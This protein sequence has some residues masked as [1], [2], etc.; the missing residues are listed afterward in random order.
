MYFPYLRGKQFELEAL[1]EVNS[2]VF[3]N[4]LP[5]LE[6]ITISRRGLYARIAAN[7]IPLILVMNPYYP[8]NGRVS[9]AQIQNII[10]NE[11]LSHTSLVLGYLIDQR[12]DLNDFNLFLNTNT[13]RE[14]AII[15]RHNPFPNALISIQSAINTQGIGYVIFDERKA[16]PRTQAAFSTHPRR[17]LLTDGFQVQQRNADYPASSTFD[18]I[19]NSWRTDGWAGIGDYLTIGDNF[20]EGGGPAY[21]VTLHITVNTTNG[22]EI[23]HFSSVSQSTR[24]ILPAQKFNEANQSLNQSSV[25]TPLNSTGLDLY[26]N[27]YANQFYP[28]LGPPKKASMMHHIELMS[29]LI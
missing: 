29:S 15:F 6:P 16:F 11:L 25:I 28:N 27:W 26:R 17:I 24:P 7:Q 2:R 23:H 8:P 20:R 9:N 1:L 22:L 14:K 21:V 4:T 12:F 10:D 19:H 5:I 18:S 3:N 13:N